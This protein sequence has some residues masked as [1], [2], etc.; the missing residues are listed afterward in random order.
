[1]A[2]FPSLCCNFFKLFLIR[3]NTTCF[4]FFICFLFV[5]LLFLTLLCKPTTEYTLQ[6]TKYTSHIT[7]NYNGIAKYISHDDDDDDD[8]D[9]LF[10]W[11][12]WPTKGVQPYFQPGPLSEILAITNLWHAASRIHDIQLLIHNAWYTI[13]NINV[14]TKQQ[15]SKVIDKIYPWD[16]EIVGRCLAELVLPHGEKGPLQPSGDGVTIKIPCGVDVLLH[17]PVS[18]PIFSYLIGYNWNWFYF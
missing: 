15:K 5:S 9:E 2:Y 3:S 7:Q 17:Q 1:M 11:Y 8:D 13:T 18:H 10:L 6:D 14:Q 4:Y 16:I 12:G